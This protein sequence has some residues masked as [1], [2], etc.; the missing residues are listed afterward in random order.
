MALAVAFSRWSLN[1][2]VTREKKRE[3]AWLLFRSA[4]QLTRLPVILYGDSLGERKFP[5]RVYRSIH[6]RQDMRTLSV[7]FSCS[8]D[9]RSL[10][11]FRV[12]LLDALQPLLDLQAALLLEFVCW[13]SSYFIDS[14]LRWHC[15]RD[16]QVNRNG[17][18]TVAV[19][20][21]KPFGIVKPA[22][23]TV[24]DNICLN[25]PLT[26]MSLEFRQRQQVYTSATSKWRSQAR[27]DG[28][29]E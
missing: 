25:G 27:L 22:E 21:V 1:A 7:A 14:F 24:C 2:H 8:V 20:I 10:R 11:F 5:V 3:Q 4:S 9:G 15:R 17:A 19:R 28:M 23:R 29:R 12:L 6:E 26:E 13:R 16:A 18:K